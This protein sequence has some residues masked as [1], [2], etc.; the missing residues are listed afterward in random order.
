MSDICKTRI[1][2][3]DANINKNTIDLK[4]GTIKFDKIRIVD[5]SIVLPIIDSIV[6]ADTII[7]ND[8]NIEHI[9]ELKSKRVQSEFEIIEEFIN[10]C[11]DFL[12]RKDNMVEARDVLLQ[13]K[14][15]ENEYKIIEKCAIHDI[16]N[17]ESKKDVLYVIQQNV[18]SMVEENR[19]YIKN[20]KNCLMVISDDVNIQCKIDNINV[21]NKLMDIQTQLNSLLDDF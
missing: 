5:N 3:L 1:R 20:V 16:D 15:D 7:E 18:G 17:I 21:L 11:R 19:R 13:S 9:D 12:S 2:P 14:L 8:N 4:T 6:N 10:S